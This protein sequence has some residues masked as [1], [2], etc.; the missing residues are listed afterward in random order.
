MSIGTFFHRVEAE[1][2]KLFRAA[3]SYE[4]KVQSV[5]ALVGP[6][7]VG[8]IGMAD[9][10]IAPEVTSVMR[11]VQSDLATVSTLTQAG[12]VAPGSTAV[13]T[14]ETAM[15]AI[16]DNVNGILSIAEV[17]NSVKVNE[18]TSAV[19]MITGEMDAMLAELPVQKAA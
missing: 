2:V 8:I 1:F 7:V 3:P 15:N 4:Q 9:P 17:K 18:I 5:I 16:K 12:Q 14:V 11:T 13:V 19:N 6:I 10:A